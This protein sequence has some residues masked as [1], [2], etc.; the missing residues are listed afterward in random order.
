MGK[1]GNITDL[2]ADKDLETQGIDLAFGGGRFI[3]VARSGGSNRK[4]RTLMAEVYKPHK[5]ALENGTLDDDTAGRLLREVFAKTVVLGWKGW[6]YAD[7]KEIP[8][9]G[10]ACEEL[11]EE[12]PEVFDIVQDESGKFANFAVQEVEEAGNE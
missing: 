10:K 5:R 7:G 6:K 11:F 2:Q 3:T 1:F 12:A 4:Y 8:Y 9:S